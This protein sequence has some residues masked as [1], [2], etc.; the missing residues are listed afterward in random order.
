MRSRSSTRSDSVSASDCCYRYR[1][2]FRFY[3]TLVFTL[4][5]CIATLFPLQCH[6]GWFSN[7]DQ[8]Q[9]NG[10]AAAATIDSEA[11]VSET[12]PEHDS[13]EWNEV[14]Q[15]HVIDAETIQQTQ[16]LVSLAIERT[17]HWSRAQSAPKDVAAI[18]DHVYGVEKNEEK[19][20]MTHNVPKRVYRTVLHPQTRQPTQMPVL[21]YQA[22]TTEKVIETAFK[23]SARV[24]I[25]EAPASNVN[26]T[27]GCDVQKFCGL[28]SVTGSP[29]WNTGDTISNPDEEQQRKLTVMS[30]NLW[31]Y[32]HWER[33]KALLTAELVRMNPAIVGFQEVRAKRL[34]HDTASR[35]QVDD[36]ASMLPGYQF[37]SR[38]AM[39][40]QEGGQE[41]HSEGVAIFSR[42]P[43]IESSVLELSQ[44][45]TDSGD[46]HKRVCQR[47][48]I[49][50]PHGRV[51]FFVT[52]LS[53]SGKSR[54]RTLPEIGEWIQSF[55]QYPAVLLGDF[56]A[57][58]DTK[59]NP[60]TKYYGMHDLW[61]DLYPSA[62]D[63]QGW[64]FNAWFPKSRIDYIFYRGLAGLSMEI[65]GTTP[66]H[67]AGL[68]PMGGVNDMKGKLFPS[69]HMLLYGEFGMIDCEP[70]PHPA[71]DTE[72]TELGPDPSTRT[73][74]EL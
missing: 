21:V 27:V 57:V 14:L 12:D 15:R 4:V 10:A 43:I 38:P 39:T 64:T 7:G 8:N 28:T 67:I 54:A 42:F 9:D 70:G 58:L 50:T 33:R 37:V 23:L 29:F 32:N 40:F 55:D 59:S 46:F 26:I 5:L 65:L 11:K 19:H 60:L 63:R 6:G 62:S 73:H 24:S 34:A 25:P 72:S 41:L 52:H 47:A 56:N 22:V 53:L 31:N 20:S 68:R 18:V 44:D 61:L 71:S 48:L 36:L 51:N 49:E 74:I 30:V 2:R 66:T 35:F 13:S 16:Q 17:K 3:T 1:Y 45:L 69:D